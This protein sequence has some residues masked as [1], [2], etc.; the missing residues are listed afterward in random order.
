MK[1]GLLNVSPPTPPTKKS[2]GSTCRVD[3]SVAFPL[4]CMRL[5][6]RIFGADSRDLPTKLEGVT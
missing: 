1:A 6:R 2:C 5:V 4:A 3:M